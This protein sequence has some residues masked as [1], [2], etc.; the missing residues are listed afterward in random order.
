MKWLLLFIGII[1]ELLGS[2]CM[3]ISK[4]FYLGAS[5]SFYVEIEGLDNFYN[6]I[7]NHIR[8]IVCH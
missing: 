3:K 7:K 6:D 4:G 1:A 2:T 8:D 5:A